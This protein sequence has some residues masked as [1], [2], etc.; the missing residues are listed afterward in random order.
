MLTRFHRPGVFVIGFHPTVHHAMRAIRRRI[1]M[2]VLFVSWRRPAMKARLLGLRA[3][4]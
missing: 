2:A 1:Q 4:P 3:S